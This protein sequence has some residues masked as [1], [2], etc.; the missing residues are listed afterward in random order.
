MPNRAVSGEQREAWRRSPSR[1]LSPKYKVLSDLQIDHGDASLCPKVTLIPS[2]GP[3]PSACLPYDSR[4]QGGGLLLWSASL[5][6]VRFGGHACCTV[7]KKLLLEAE[8]QGK[9]DV[10]GDYNPETELAR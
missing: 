4:R 3:K 6:H 5:E 2:C 10:G 7:R 9:R 1:V 8:K